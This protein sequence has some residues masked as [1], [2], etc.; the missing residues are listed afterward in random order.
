MK[1]HDPSDPGNDAFVHYMEP[2]ELYYVIK[3]WVAIGKMASI[4]YMSKMCMHWWNPFLVP[5]NM[6][7]SLLHPLYPQY[8]VHIVKVRA[9]QVW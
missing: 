6:L 3:D 7:Y 5:H 8:T 1:D 4:S 9:T 2:Q